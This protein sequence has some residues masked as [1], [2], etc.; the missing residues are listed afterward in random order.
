MFITEE[1]ASRRFASK[2]NILGPA[3]KPKRK[4]SAEELAQKSNLEDENIDAPSLISRERVQAILD[5]S[6]GVRN[7]NRNLNGMT[8]VQIGIGT[9]S[10][11]LGKKLASNLVGLSQKQTY[12]Y[13]MGESGNKDLED[14]ITRK[15]ARRAAME[16]IKDSLAERAAQR[17]GVAL[18]SLTSDKISQERSAGNI[19][20]IAKDM[21][22]VVDKVTKDNGTP[23][24]VHFHIFRPAPKTV[25]D[26][27]IVPVRSSV[28]PIDISPTGPDDSAS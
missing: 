18:D 28:A 4:Y 13:E 26:Y 7:R 19:A 2:N 17:L 20:R 25:A 9:T 8:D 24:H 5:A 12:A 22:V 16:S 14:G 21:A 15:P 3:Y 10:A 23:E 1:E 11:I 6:E 27:K